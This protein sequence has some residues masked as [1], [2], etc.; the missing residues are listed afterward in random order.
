MTVVPSLSL[1][2]PS[3]SNQFGPSRI[4]VPLEANFVP[5]GLVDGGFLAH[6]RSPFVFSPGGISAARRSF[7]GM[8]RKVEAGVMSE[9][10]HMW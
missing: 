3:P 7:G 6:L 4:E 2:R 10:H 8:R 1:V 9:H 5:P